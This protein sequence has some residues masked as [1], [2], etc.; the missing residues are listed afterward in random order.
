MALICAIA[1]PSFAVDS[2]EITMSPLEDVAEVLE[3]TEDETVA[4][5]S[6]ETRD[7]NSPSSQV[8]IWN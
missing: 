3:D 8:K 5:T 2:Q 7:G 4:I 1:I 6:K